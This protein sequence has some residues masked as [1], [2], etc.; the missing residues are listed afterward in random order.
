MTFSAGGT[1][2]ATTAL[3]RPIRGRRSKTSVAPSRS[4]RISAVPSVGNSWVA[5]TWSSVV[6][7]AP[8]GPMTT[9]R[10]SS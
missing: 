9:H 7:P 10:S 8:L 2:S 6:L 3:A 4:P 5:A 1:W